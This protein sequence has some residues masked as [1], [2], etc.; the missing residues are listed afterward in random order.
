MA[1]EYLEQ[2][3]VH[4]DKGDVFAAGIIL[5]ILFFGFPPYKEK[6]SGNDPYYK[7]IRENKH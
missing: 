2:S 5:F 6:A 4:A 7:L 3:V 1:P